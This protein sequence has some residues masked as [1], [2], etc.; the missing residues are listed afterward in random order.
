MLYV[1]KLY[2]FL[3]LQLLKPHAAVCHCVQVCEIK[4][5]RMT[6]QESMQHLFLFTRSLAKLPLLEKVNSFFLG[7]RERENRKNE[8]RRSGIMGLVTV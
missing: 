5:E 7:E 2:G 6:E 3:L 8:R 4:S 1:C